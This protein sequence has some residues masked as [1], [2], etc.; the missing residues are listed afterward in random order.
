MRSQPP[1]GQS[2]HAVFSL[3]SNFT[4]SEGHSQIFRNCRQNC[5]FD[6]KIYGVMTLTELLC[7]GNCAIAQLTEINLKCHLYVSKCLESIR[8]MF[9]K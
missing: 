7:L 9:K 2:E 1:G 3:F 6:R 8:K 4:G 5:G